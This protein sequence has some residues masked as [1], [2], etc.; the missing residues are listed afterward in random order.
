MNQ[1]Q[2][3]RQPLSITDGIPV[4]V[5]SDG[6]IENYDQIASD[7]LATAPQGE[8][9]PFI[10]DIDWRLME[11]STAD[12]IARVAQPGQSLLDIGVGTGR[13]IDMFSEQDKHGVDISIDYLRLA[14]QKGISP[15]LAKAE[16]LPFEDKSFDIIVSTDVLEHVLD[17]NAAI[18]E[19]YRVLKPGGHLIVRVPYREELSSYLKED[20]PYEFAH[21]RNFDE[22]GLQ[23]L[24]SRIFKFNFIEESYVHLIIDHRL[25]IQI[26]RLKSWFSGALRR[27]TKKSPV[28]YEKLAKTLYRPIFIN[29]LVQRREDTN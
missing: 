11:N 27:I 8:D 19:M 23:L 15:Y 14:A 16:E 2:L 22:Y 13:L 3:I 29:T 6:Y 4:F 24:F 17:L 28:L 5:E 21:L 18:A 26:P 9:N 20:Y 25:H 7:H 12:M 1:I 10:T